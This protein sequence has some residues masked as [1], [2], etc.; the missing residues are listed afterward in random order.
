MQTMVQSIGELILFEMKTE[1]M[2][3]TKLVS[4]WN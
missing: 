1:D 4:W 3:N 2:F